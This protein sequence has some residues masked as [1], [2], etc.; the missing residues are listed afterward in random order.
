MFVSTPAFAPIPWTATRISHQALR[1][2]EFKMA[3]AK[4]YRPRCFFDMEI[5]GEPGTFP[6]VEAK[7]TLIN[8][9]A[10]W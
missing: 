7:E 4:G 8:V 6:I 10:F 3:P 2:G 9:F 5:N 1:G